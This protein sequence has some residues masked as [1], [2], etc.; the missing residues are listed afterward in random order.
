MNIARTVFANSQDFSNAESVVWN[1]LPQ[2]LTVDISSNASI[3]CNL[4]NWLYSKSC[5]QLFFSHI[6]IA[7]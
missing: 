7:P 3:R 6:A 5:P 1:S 4:E 2:Q